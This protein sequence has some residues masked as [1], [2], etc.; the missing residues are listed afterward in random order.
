MIF[1]DISDYYVGPLAVHEDDEWQRKQF[2]NDN[3]A[4]AIPL[5]VEHGV[6]TV[7]DFGCGSGLLAVELLR[8]LPTVYYAGVDKNDYFL[9]Q[10]RARVEHHN[11]CTFAKGDVRDNTRG[12]DLVMAWAF[13]KH[14][15][16]HE[17]DELVAKAI[18]AGNHAAF[19]VQFL[20]H[21]LDDG[22]E[23]H[24]VFVTRERFLRALDA[25]GH[26]IVS[27]HVARDLE[28]PGHGRL[29]ENFFWT[30]KRK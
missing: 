3:L 14:F 22:T 20:D 12:S 18:A 9:G 13:F 7:L 19:S 2:Y 6:K 15:G 1:P 16:L 8:V 23:Y 11:R 21:D 30:S 26:E 5:I 28:L 27:E 4:F 25:A 24:H 10:A 29:L 17:W